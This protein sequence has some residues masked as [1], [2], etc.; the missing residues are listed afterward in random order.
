MD[1]ESGHWH[2]EQPGGPADEI[3]ARETAAGQALT[4]LVP[5]LIVLLTAVA[6]WPALDGEFLDWD[7][8][9]LL[10]NNLHYRGSGAA[11]LGWMFTTNLLGH[12][13]PVN[14]ISFALDY[15][16]WDMG[17]R[18]YHATNLILF[19]LGALVFYRVGLR[20]LG[21]MAAGRKLRGRAGLTA[22]A[23]LAAL[24]YAVHPL[25]VETVA[26]VT[27]RAYVLSGL[28]FLLCVL[29]Y[30]RYVDRRGAGSGGGLQ[31]GMA[32]AFYAL[33]LFSRANAVGLPIV[34]VL[35]DVYPL[36]RLKPAPREWFRPGQ[37]RLW[38]EK[39][40]FLVLAVV[41]AGLAQWAKTSVGT[42]ATVEAIPLGARMA[43]GVYA[44]SFYLL[45]T[46]WPSGLLPLYEKPLEINPFE[47][48]Y[49]WS[50]AVV[51]LV[52]VV[53]FR[54]RRR[55]R[56]GWVLWL[57]YLVM[58]A[59][60]SGLVQIGLQMAADRYTQLACLG[61]ALLAGAGFLYCWPGGHRARAGPAPAVV[62]TVLSAAVVI[63]LVAVSRQQSR[64]WGDRE[65]LWRTT[66]AGNAECIT[67]LNNLTTILGQ[68]DRRDE[69]MELARRAEGLQ[70]E[71]PGI[72]L[73]LGSL[74]LEQ[75]RYDEAI[76]HFNKALDTG[77]AGADVYSNLGVAWAGKGDWSRALQHLE[78]AA[79]LSPDNAEAHYNLGIVYSQL[80]RLAEAENEFA[81]ALRLRP[82]YADAAHNLQVIRSRRE[83]PDRSARP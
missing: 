40:P 13:Q 21:G 80:N 58:V 46:L 25:R 6:F 35:L 64:V 32:V 41:A 16:L 4:W 75:G 42:V 20:L 3:P 82:D 43:M 37:G 11:Q 83:D 45:K 12:Y 10:V 59:P 65:T 31:L 61:W 49:L 53:L 38:L 71:F 44:L 47:A 19:A 52:T 81:Q 66:L 78:K 1:S 76:E 39:M 72:Q 54:L 56:A 15:R 5:L 22:A 7:D 17:P 79:S 14:W 50:G 77:M 30:L 73:N 9:K 23:G 70:P 29:F 27:N 74:L 34:L 69:A 67:A 8:D 2:S 51:V 36:N 24:L 55:W 26:W 68:S 63:A 62:V 28:F 60:V 18:G 33:S 57:Y 48:I